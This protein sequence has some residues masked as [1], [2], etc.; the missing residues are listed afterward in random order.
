MTGEVQP[1]IPRPKARSIRGEPLDGIGWHGHPKSLAFGGDRGGKLGSGRFWVI[2]IEYKN[3]NGD[4]VGVESYTGFGY[5]RDAA[6]G[7][8]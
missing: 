2:D 8:A 6:G 7:A 1:L 3:Q 4:L 5:R